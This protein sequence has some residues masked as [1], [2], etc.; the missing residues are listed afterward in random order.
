[1]ET[2]KKTESV[3]HSNFVYETAL[4]HIRTVLSDIE[5]KRERSY[6]ESEPILNQS[7]AM[8]AHTLER[9]I[10]D[11]DRELNMKKSKLQEVESTVVYH[12]YLC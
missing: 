3:Q 8:V 10:Q 12:I 5:K 9:C 6:F 7:P 2:N 11:L 4:K 1:M